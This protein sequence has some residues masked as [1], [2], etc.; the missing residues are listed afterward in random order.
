MRSSSV[1]ALLAGVMLAGAAPTA[2]F[3]SEQLSTRD[4]RNV[5]SPA[6]IAPET[7]KRDGVTW[8]KVKDTP[9]GVGVYS[10]MPQTS[11]PHKRD[12]M[13]KIGDTPHGG[14]YSNMPP[15]PE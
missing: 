7:R 6:R 3:Q 1:I 13:Y 4:T 2:E 5:G 14:V 15:T 8:Y 12:N 9:D 10:S 11:N